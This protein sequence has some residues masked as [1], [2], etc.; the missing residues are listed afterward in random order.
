M[1]INCLLLIM[2]MLCAKAGPALADD[3]LPIPADDLVYCTTC[4]G[5]QLMG[6]PI[7]R[8]PRM[9]GLDAWYVENQLRAFKNGWRGAHESDPVG[10]EMQPM[11]AA[12]SEKQIVAAAS[13]VA[14]TRSAAPAVTVS[15][16]TEA[17]KLIYASCGAC[18][19][20]SGEGNETLGAPRLTGTNDW[21]LVTQLENYV[22][23]SRG[24]HSDDIYGMQM[25]A[26]AQLLTD[27]KAILDVVSYISTLNN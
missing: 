23:G 27:E 4:H 21:Y 6:N 15:G 8:A 17:G 25:R 9:S 12:L 24:S 3:D 2:T 10:M 13:F 20:A 11:A 19:G 16:D 7:T 1:R 26:S 14:S 22:N 18:H 5:V